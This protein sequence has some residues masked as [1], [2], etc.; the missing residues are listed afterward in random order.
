MKEFIKKLIGRLTYLLNNFGEHC[1][2]WGSDK[3]GDCHRKS[4]SDCVLTHAIEIVNE[5]AEEYKDKDCSQTSTNTSSGWISVLERL[6]RLD[7]YVLCFI[8]DEYA[9]HNII[10]SKFDDEIYWHNG[11]ITAWMPLPQPYIEQQKELSTTWQQQTMRK[12]ERVE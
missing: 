10:I 12:F 5:L 3:E 1:E 6:P 8:N 9:K 2:E 11:R 7:E 4:C